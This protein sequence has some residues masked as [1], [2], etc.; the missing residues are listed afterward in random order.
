M[1]KHT[2]I[3]ERVF[4]WK[5][6]IGV[7]QTEN[8]VETMRLLLNMPLERYDIDQRA[9]SLKVKVIEPLAQ[10]VLYKR[11]VDKKKTKMQ[12]LLYLAIVQWNSLWNVWKRCI[13]NTRAAEPPKVL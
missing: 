12:S 11:N 7:P 3:G 2:A 5:I 4:T 13:S 1:V 6:Y 8:N 10:K 9:H